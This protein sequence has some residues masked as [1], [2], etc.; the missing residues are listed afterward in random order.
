ME[1]VVVV[2]YQSGVGVVS[3]DELEEAIT[4]P[5]RTVVTPDGWKLNYSPLGEHELYHLF[6]DPGEIVNLFG[7]KQN[8]AI[9]DELLDRILQW[10]KRTG[11][12]VKLPPA[13]T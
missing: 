2:S 11:D 12:S 9:V 4:D 7:R 8:R 5:V 6:R 13:R 1:N 10:Q 3:H